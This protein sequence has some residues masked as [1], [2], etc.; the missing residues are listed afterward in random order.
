MTAKRLHDEVT[1][2]FNIFRSKCLGCRHRRVIL[3]WGCRCHAF[4]GGP[5]IRTKPRAG[6]AISTALEATVRPR[7]PLLGAESFAGF[8]QF[9]ISHNASETQPAGRLETQLATNRQANHLR[10]LTPGGPFRYLAGL[11]FH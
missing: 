10:T 8:L 6:R 2:P 3:R 7:A 11:T 1:F 4:E 5:A 9:R